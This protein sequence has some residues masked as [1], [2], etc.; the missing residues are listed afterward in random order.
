VLISF[1]GEQYGE[2][3]S[4]AAWMAVGVPFVAVFLPLAWF[5]LTRV[6]HPVR[7]SAVEGGRE[8]IRGELRALGPMQSGE[9]IVMIVFGLTAAAWI[10]RPLIVEW[11]GLEARGID[12]HDATIGMAGALALFLI[13]V[14][15]KLSTFALDWEWASRAP[16]GILLLFGG[17]L[18]LAGAMSATALDATLGQVFAGLKGL[19]VPVLIF[20]VSILVIFLTEL[21]SNTA[22]TA[23]L[24]PVLA[25]AADALAMEPMLLLVPAAIAASCAFMLPV[26]TPPNA[27][28][29]THPR[30]QIGHMARAGLVLNLVGALLITLLAWVWLPVAMASHFR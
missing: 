23:A 7:L 14:D 24:M 20:S 1:I 28:V 25:G 18:S 4:F 17:G 5:L 6:L 12:L 19:P 8:L 11:L 21:T 16:F 27:I 13:P 3:I 22:V 2:R 26:A 15:R 30:I 10:V 9:I 29:F